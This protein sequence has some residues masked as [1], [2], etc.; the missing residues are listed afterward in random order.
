MD[1]D[2]T[3]YGYRPRPGQHCARWGPSSPSPKR[4][5]SAPP[6]ILSPCLFSP[7]GWMD[8]EATWYE[9]RPRPSETVLDGD[10]APLQSGQRPANFRPMSIVPKRPDG[11][12][13]HLVGRSRHRRHCVTWGPSSPLLKGAQPPI[14]GL[15]LLWPNGRPSQLLLSTC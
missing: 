1:Q 3:W 14:F 11:S 9:G 2:A 7:N 12:R 4:R 5:H 6:Q 8:Q 10:P 13:C 15:C